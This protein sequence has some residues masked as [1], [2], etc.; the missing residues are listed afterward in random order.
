MFALPPLP[1]LFF[2][3]RSFVHRLHASEL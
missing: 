2:I 1:L 3:V